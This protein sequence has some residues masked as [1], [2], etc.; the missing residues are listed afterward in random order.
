[1]MIDAGQHFCMK[2]SAS[3]CV[4]GILLS[5]ATLKFPRPVLA[6]M[7]KPLWSHSIS[8]AEKFLGQNL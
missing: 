5:P 8:K 4:Q 1:M 3:D 2:R 7:G 6:M